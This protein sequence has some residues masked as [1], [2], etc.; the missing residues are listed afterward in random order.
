MIA[1]NIQLLSKEATPNFSA[2]DIVKI[3]KFSKQKGV[4]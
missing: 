3:R 1:N 4:S 2:Q